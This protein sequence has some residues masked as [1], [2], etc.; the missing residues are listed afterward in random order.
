MREMSE[1]EDRINPVDMVDVSEKQVVHRTAEAAGRITLKRE[2]LKAIKNGMIKKGDPFPVAEV[3]GI[4]AAK[5]TS[6]LIPLCHLIPLTKVDVS[7]RVAEDY[8]EAM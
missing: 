8:V 7:F 2:T 3:A 5:K 4:L 6:E 1:R